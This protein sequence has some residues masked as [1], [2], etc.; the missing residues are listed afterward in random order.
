MSPSL[1]VAGAV[2]VIALAAKG[3][4]PNPFKS[5]GKVRGSLSESLGREFVKALQAEAQEEV[6][7]LVAKKLKDDAM[8]KLG[9]PFGLD[10][11]NGD[12]A[13]AAK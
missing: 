13:P 3:Y 8:A 4:L 2:A 11:P 1:I 9:T 6:A 7:S 5:S 10:S 12:Q